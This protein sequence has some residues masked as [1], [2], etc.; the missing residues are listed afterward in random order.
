M[1]GGEIKSTLTLDVSKFSS[2][3]EKAIGG[4]ENLEK[5]L[6]SAA[7]VAADFDK[8]ITGVGNDLSNIAK[9]FR[10]LD[11]TVESMVTK[12]TGIVARFDQLGQ[13]SSMAAKGVEQLGSA[14]KKTTSLNADQWI[15][16]YS[17]ELDKLA[18]ALRNAVS[19]IIDFDRANIASANIAEKTAE[20]NAQARL[21]TLAAERDANKKII[22][23]RE[24]MAAELRAIE[25][26][27][28]KRADANI[29]AANKQY[30]GKNF[31]HPVGQ[32]WRSEAATAQGAAATAA[33]ERAAL[34]AVIKEMKWQNAEIEKRIALEKQAIATIAEKTK[35]EKDAAA[36]TAAAKKAE[37]EAAAAAREAAAESARYARDAAKE[38]MRAAREAADF[39]RQQAREIAQMWK[40]MGQLW[41]ASKIEQGMK[42]GIGKASEYQQTD[43]RVRLLNLPTAEYE[44]FKKK[45]FDITKEEKYLSV[46]DAMQARLDALTAI[47][48]NHKEAIDGTM[49]SALRNAQVMLSAGY[50]HGS[51]SDLIKNLYGFA[52]SRQV[53]NDPAKIIESFDIARRMGVASGGKINIAD[54][55]T[56]AR[57]MGDLRQTMSADGW[58]GVA[59]LMEQFKVAGS[60]GHGGAGAGVSS[61][62]TMLKMMSL[63]AAGKPVTNQAAIQLLGADVMNDVYAAGSAEQFKNSAVTQEAFRRAVKT[64]GFKGVKEMS[65]N[66]VDFFSGLRGNLMAYMKDDKNKAKFFDTEDT[67]SNAA[68]S[69]ALKRFFAR[70]GMSNK[71]VDGML[72]MMNKAFIERSNHVRQLAKEAADEEKSVN[73]MKETWKNAVDEMNA[74]AANLAAAFAPALKPL[75]EIPKAIGAI[76]N[77]AAEFVKDN[78]L[79][80]FADLALVALGGLTLA[81]KGAL[82]TFGMVGGVMNSVRT[83]MTAGAT[84]TA[85]ATSAWGG[86][87]AMVLA[88]GLSFQKLI[89]PMETVITVAARVG[90]ALIAPFATVAAGAAGAIGWIGKLGVSLLGFVARWASPIGWAALAAQFGWVVGEWISSLKLGGITI[91]DHMQNIFLDIELGWK[92]MLLK[93]QEKWI[94][95]KKMIGGDD[96]LGESAERKEIEAERA[97]LAQYEKDMRITPQEPPKVAPAAKTGDGHGHGEKGGKTGDKP[98]VRDVGDPF[99]KAPRQQRFFEDAFARQFYGADTRSNIEQLKLDAL[100]S[101][102]ANYAEQARQEVIKMWMGGDLDDGKDPSKRKFVKG[103]SYDKEGRVIGYNPLTGYTPDQMDWNAQVGIGK[104]ASGKDV[105]KSLADLQAEIAERKKLADIINGVKYATERAAAADEEASLAMKR[106]TGETQ[107]QT[108]AMRALNREFARQEKANPAIGNDKDYQAKKIAALTNQAIADY[109]NMGAGLVQ[110]NKE[111]EAQFLATERERLEAGVQA[112]YEAKRREAQIVMDQLDAQVLALEEAGMKGSDL[113][114]KAIEARRQGE[115]EFTRYLKNIAEERAR[116]LETPMQKM[117]R[118]W[119]DVYDQLD[120]LGEQWASGFMD[121]LGDLITTGKADWR[122]FTVSMLNDLAKVMLKKSF[123]DMIG[124][125]EGMGNLG[126]GGLIKKGLGALGFGMGPAPSKMVNGTPAFAEDAPMIGAGAVANGAGDALKQQAEELGQSLQGVAQSADAA[127]LAQEAMTVATEGNTVVTEMNSVATQMDTA[128]VEASTVATTVDTVATE[129]ETAAT[130]V[131]ATSE[132]VDAAANQYDASTEIANAAAN[133]YDAYTEYLANGG[134]ADQFGLSFF[135]NGGAFTNGIYSEPTLFK[136]ANGGQFGVMGEAGPE[137]VMPLSRDGK[138]RLGV[139]VNNAEGGGG[140]GAAPVVNIAITVNK[141]GGSSSS[142]SGDDASQ[143]RQMADR[144]KGIVIQEITTQ[145][146]PG[147]L[148]YK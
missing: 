4:T 110:K 115:E 95:F 68:E 100:I 84:A 12:L 62:G 13:H 136:F 27:M 148:L 53:M 1:A 86:L 146:R 69:A 2:A 105:K 24:R 9:S 7:K 88:V 94:D 89:G 76:L 127:G 10:L 64:A 21:K 33:S 71:T 25:E 90:S 14:V 91:G 141:D 132:M 83:M 39:E 80:G 79:V 121:Q 36:A 63:Y 18:P 72:T 78:P 28:Q 59:A 103:A 144:V 138:G 35:A 58:M 40:G 5:H 96:F 77:K 98:T 23:D 60:Q 135:A 129:A 126:L 131:A 42:A 38:R 143:W 85:A 118:E 41:A 133:Q 34:E 32:M 99:A 56:V 97:R 20:K 111:M 51:R 55:E 139:T 54:M 8:G 114:V 52:E 45:A 147:G 106:L 66:P 145:Q 124:G 82:N 67:E 49:Q 122:K 140:S 93:I 29:A 15:K 130:T 81:V 50:E 70:M 6:K 109:A 92:R 30:F 125:P 57:N 123:A 46:M 116:A 119:A 142:Q 26:Q 75:S 19:S 108:D 128:A 112:T 37:R 11:Q 137:A 43:V 107:G 87:R 113:W 16:K 117:V 22:A 48:H 61:V 31:N 47:G 102:G 73:E 134:V 65:E 3:L 17:N 104:D 101:G 120:K 44:E 74:G